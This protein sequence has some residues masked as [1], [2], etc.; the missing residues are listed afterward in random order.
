[1]GMPFMLHYHVNKLCR[2]MILQWTYRSCDIMLMN[3]LG[4]TFGNMH[5]IHVTYNVNELC[6]NNM[7]QWAYRSC[8]I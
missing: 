3:F 8:Y 4:R 6:R 2:K 1:M 7:L 5:I